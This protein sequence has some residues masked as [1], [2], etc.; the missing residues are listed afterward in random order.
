M[1]RFTRHIA[2]RT[3]TLVPLLLVCLCLII[4]WSL[5]LFNHYFP[6]PLS[7]Q[8]FRRVPPYLPRQ[9]STAYPLRTNPSRRTKGNGVDDSEGPP[10][11]AP[12]VAVYFGRL[13]RA[14]I[15]LPLIKNLFDRCI[16]VLKS[17]KRSESS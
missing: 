6:L 10:S 12:R 2:R 9:L 7:V 13:S 8:G 14:V 16:S 17:V 11:L 3:V 15:F 1:R 4:A 5:T